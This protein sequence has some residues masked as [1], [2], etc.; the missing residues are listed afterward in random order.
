M[1]CLLLEIPTSS[2]ALIVHQHAWESWLVRLGVDTVDDAPPG[3][4]VKDWHDAGHLVGMNSFIFE[5]EPAIG[6]KVER[7]FAYGG[8]RIFHVEFS[9]ASCNMPRFILGL[10]LLLPRSGKRPAAFDGLE[11]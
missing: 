9:G 11:P 7:R 2:T 10:R 6:P 1:G 4:V 8:G 3:F 5:V